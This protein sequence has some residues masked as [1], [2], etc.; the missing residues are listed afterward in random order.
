MAL[1]QEEQDRMLAEYVALQES[2]ARRDGDDDSDDGLA[3]LMNGVLAHSSE[4][5]KLAYAGKADGDNFSFVSTTSVHWDPYN[6]TLAEAPQ[7]ESGQ[8]PPESRMI[9]M[10][11]TLGERK[12][13]LTLRITA[14]SHMVVGKKPDE[15][16][17][18]PPP[19]SKPAEPEVFNIMGWGQEENGPF[20]FQFTGEIPRMQK[21]LPISQENI[22][23]MQV[24][25]RLNLQVGE[26]S[27]KK[28]AVGS[29]QDESASKKPR[30]EEDDAPEEE[31]DEWK[32]IVFLTDIVG[33]IQWKYSIVIVGV[34]V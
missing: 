26:D 14:E 32:P 30:L 17:K 25:C 16:R 19:G 2:Q 11:G 5:N 24:Q 28:P 29:S 21:D 13:T 1:S 34:V 33:N 7:E 8:A 22:Q 27:R 23:S 10:E 9:A 4:N 15:E 12:V 6:M 3:Y 18:K 20:S 31:D